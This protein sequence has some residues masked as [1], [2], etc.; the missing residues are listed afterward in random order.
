MDDRNDI[1][2]KGLKSDVGVGFRFHGPM[3][4]PLRI[5]LAR[6]NEGLSLVFSSKA[7]F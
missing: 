1:S 7:P 5:E 2:L 4:T 3:T 6:G